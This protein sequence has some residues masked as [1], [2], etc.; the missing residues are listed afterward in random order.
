MP[1]PDF[2]TLDVLRQYNILDSTPEEGFD[3]L[4]R[5]AAQLGGVSVGLI[6]F[7]RGDSSALAGEDRYWLKALTGWPEN[8]PCHPLVCL[9][10]TLAAEDGLLV[11]DLQQDERFVFEPITVGTP[12]VRFYAGVPLLSPAGA[13]LGVLA[14][15]GWEPGNPS[16]GLMDGLRL[17]ARQVIAQLELRRRTAALTEAIA[18]HHAAETEQKLLFSLS[19][20]LACVMGADGY[21]KRLN[22]AWR[23]LLGYTAA[24]LMAKPFL[25]FIH[26]DDWEI[27]LN[28]IQKV[29]A[30]GKKVTFQNR[31]RHRDGSY[32]RLQWRIGPLQDRQ[33]LCATASEVSAD[34][35]LDPKPPQY[36]LLSDLA[37]ALNQHSIAAV[38]DPQGKIL[39]AN[40][41]FCEISWYSREELIGQDHRLISSGYHS[42]E[43]FRDMWQTISSGN[44]WRG[45]IC[46]RAKNNIL[47]WVD[48]TIVPI[49]DETG[50]PQRYIALRTDITERKEAEQELKARS[51]LAELGAAV[52][53]TLSQGGTVID[54]LKRC[55]A[56]LV[57]YLDAHSAYVW[58]LNPET[59]LLELQASTG[60]YSCPKEFQNRIPIGISVIGYAAQTRQP[61]LTDNVLNDMCIGSKDWL[62]Q[63]RIVGFAAYPLVT[64]DRLIGVMALFSHL[65]FAQTVHKTLGWI[66]N[67]LAVAIDRTLAREELLSRREALLFRLASQI[68]ASL[69]LEAI[70]ETTVSEVWS[71]LQVDR[72]QFLWCRSTLEATRLE[73]THEARNPALLSL[74]GDYPLGPGRVLGEK[75]LNLEMVRIADGR[76]GAVEPGLLEVLNRAD[77]VAH[78]L[79]P[80]ETRSHK[81]GA[82][83]C[84]HSSP[85]AWTDSEVELL[86]AV[87]DQVAIAIDQAEL[88]AHS[89]EAAIA[90]EA[91]AAQLSQ[92]LQHLQQTQAH[93]IQSEKMSSLGQMVAGIAH[94]INNPVNFING[95]LVHANNY[96]K[97][98]LHLLNLY[99]NHIPD[100]PDEVAQALQSIDLDFIADDLPKLMTS[101]KIGADRIRQIVLSLRNFSRLDEAE[102]KPVDI[103]EGIDSTLL[104]L[105]NRLK[106]HAEGTGIDV[107][108]EY[109]SL[110]KVECYAGQLNQVFMN[111]LVNA[112]DALEEC[113]P[114][115]RITISTEFVPQPAIALA[116]PAEPA[117]SQSP[118]PTGCVVI[119]IADNGPGISA[120]TRDRLFDPFFTTKPVGKGTGLGL[121]IS[122]QIVVQRH[123]GSL[124]CESEVGKGTTFIIRIP[125]I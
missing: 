117:P 116:P 18:Q 90:A 104:I 41:K 29:V 17:L 37:F 11:I 81:L 50:K 9:D 57:Q 19:A 31:C 122:Y 105:Q 14:V 109:G 8:T 64:E 108:K 12:A 56:Q 125:L 61:Y 88:Y 54:I 120:E 97:D 66:S 22:P 111:I 46:N 63:E 94:E 68:R 55:T 38:T 103:H 51:H 76:P 62:E 67:S 58:T 98:L 77:A 110:P 4:A 70:L 95:N 87:A 123:G 30:K 44:V 86:Q 27:T 78:L 99:Q 93:L 53:V 52:G 92:T 107:E 119:R 118:E 23:K 45:E 80:L 32:H 85:R 24:E 34:A 73:I 15:M 83:A 113:P 28:H 60:G 35:P 72:C 121:S 75:V 114:P 10:S 96:T 47:Y 124:E 13:A 25:E 42:R 112:I 48:T 2:A 49:L 36:D 79:M 102:K 100:P 21:L 115:R 7:L 16:E 74:L 39:Y 33:L 69:D 1:V 71:L 59:R 101:M 82:I 26:P 91:Q 43:F 3:G 20:H 5:L 106:N 89:R 40:D 84:Y 6:A 65:P